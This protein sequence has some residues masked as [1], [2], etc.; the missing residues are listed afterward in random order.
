RTAGPVRTWLELRSTDLVLAYTAGVSTSL[1]RPPYL[2]TPD[3]LDDAAWAAARRLGDAARLVVMSNVDSKDW[4]R[5]GVEAIVANSTP[6]DEHGV[7]LLM[8]DSGGDRSQTV[9]A[10]DKLIPAWQAAGW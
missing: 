9:A 3:E 7:V 1:A 8:H 10:L 6:K 4:R 2:G 5:P